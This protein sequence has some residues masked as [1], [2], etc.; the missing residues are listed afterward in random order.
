MLYAH[1][2]HVEDERE[3][4]TDDSHAGTAQAE[5][6]I[7]VTAAV[8]RIIAPVLRV[9]IGTQLQRQQRLQRPP[10]L[11]RSLRLRTVIAQLQGPHV[12]RIKLR[13]LIC[14]LVFRSN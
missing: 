11:T 13:L 14:S 10:L 6:K 9:T 1:A 7:A 2:T 3:N 8:L 12:R 5:T 4:A